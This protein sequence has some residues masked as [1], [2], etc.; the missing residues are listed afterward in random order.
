MTR[1]YGSLSGISSGEAASQVARDCLQFNDLLPGLHNLNP[2]LSLEGQDVEPMFRYK[3]QDASA[4][5]WPAWG[6]GGDLEYVT[7]NAGTQFNFGSPFQGPLDDSVKLAGVSAQ[8]FFRC[9]DTTT[10]SITTEDWWLELLVRGHNPEG[11]SGGILSKFN[12]GARW[13]MSINSFNTVT[14]LIHNG[15]TSASHGISNPI[16]K[17]WMYLVSI[18]HRSGNA[19]LFSNMVRSSS[20]NI[21]ALAESSLDGGARLT[22]AGLDTGTNTSQCAIAYMA[23]YKLQDW[24]STADQQDMVNE[25]FNALWTAGVAP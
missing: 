23:G 14:F 18:G 22:T 5:G 19:M 10:G 25:R 9:A 15:T 21:S 16:G 24:L 12:T 3:G 13:Q 7:P 8:G 17:P 6:Y 11:G 4:D 2:I 1:V 20:L